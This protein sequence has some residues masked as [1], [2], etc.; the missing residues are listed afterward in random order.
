MIRFI[1]VVR[2]TIDGKVYVGQTKDALKRQ[3]DHWCG[4]R[5]G[6]SGY[7]Y[8]AMRKHGVEN[9]SFSVVEECAEVHADERERWWIAEL[10]A[11][12]REHGYNLESGGHARKALSEETRQ[13]ISE[14]LKGQAFSEER[15]ARIS[16]GKTGR[17]VK[18]SAER[19]IKI[20]QSLHRRF[21][22]VES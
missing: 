2:N 9:F 15:R 10:K 7:L 18:F 21:H 6:R 1:Y 17:K 11:C 12:S 13:K 20:S 3:R 19:D 5:Y 22:G 16:K 14:A 4:V 8:N